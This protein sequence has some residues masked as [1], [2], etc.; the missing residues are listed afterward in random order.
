MKLSFLHRAGSGH[1]PCQPPCKHVVGIENVFRVR[2]MSAE[3]LETLRLT[4]AY[5]IGSQSFRSE[6]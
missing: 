6:K 2:E 4:A 5:E 1:P 3:A